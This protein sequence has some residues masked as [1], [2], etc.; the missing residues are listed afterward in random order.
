MATDNVFIPQTGISRDFS[1]YESPQG[2]FSRL[3]NA[4]LV[5]GKGRIEQT[6]NF[7][8]S[9]SFPAG[10][11]YNS[12]TVTETGFPFS[13][14]LNFFTHGT[15]QVLQFTKEVGRVGNAQR[16]VFR[17]TA[18]PTNPPSATSLN[19]GCYLEVITASTLGITLGNTLDVVI[20]SATTFKWRVN[21]GAYTTGVPITTTGVSISSNSAILYFL[22]ATG[23][24]VNDTWS[25][26]RTDRLSEGTAGIDYI[27]DWSYC[28]D[29]NKVFFIDNS[30]RVMLYSSDLDGIVTVGYR[31]IYGTHLAIYYKHLF[32]FGT[33]QS[34]NTSTDPINSHGTTRQSNIANSDLNDYNAFFSTD[35]NEA[36]FFNLSSNTVPDNNLSNSG[37][38]GCSVINGILSGYTC[39]RIWSTNYNGLPT[40]FSFQ[41]Y[42]V[43]SLN[44]NFIRPIQTPNGDYFIGTG[45]IFLFDGN[46][47]SLISSDV[48]EVITR[49]VSFNNIVWGFYFV[50]RRE[51]YFLCASESNDSG[52]S[53]FWVYQETTQ[54]W[55]FRACSF[56]SLPRSVAIIGGNIVT[57][58]PL[59]IV[60]EDTSGAQSA[61]LKDF[62]SGAS[63]QLPL[64]ET[65]DLVF[66]NI[67]QVV[68]LEG[69]YLDVFYTS[70]SGGAYGTTGVTLECSTRVYDQTTP[71][72]PGGSQIGTWTT[73]STDGTLSLHCSGR[74][75]RFRIRP[76]VTSGK[77]AFGFEF[78]TLVLMVTGASEDDIIR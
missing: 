9:A 4:R 33:D 72:Y 76:T 13:L 56:T 46:T 3:V 39:N 10:T 26:T 64:I 32:V 18:Y 67:S 58:I 25:W 28:I 55:Y 38:F 59:S 14:N 52:T 71:T 22:T 65:S 19:G 54:S 70:P 69:T 74:L 62:N 75:W 63:F 20:D 16:K 49:S 68:D 77:A 11:Y 48:I 53:G 43:I 36:D 23:F 41:E 30:G 6:P 1:P 61:A 50:E 31:P 73:S 45:G 57:S 66:N 37:F 2:S 12:G 8:I 60:T 29:G 27:Y 35:T 44:T 21:G 34:T 51:V 7:Y 47:V 17:Q 5:P 24:T 15:T 42:R 40:P 78:N